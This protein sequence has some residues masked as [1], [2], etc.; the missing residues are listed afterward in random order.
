MLLRS[1]YR[2]CCRDLTHRFNLP[3][4]LIRTC[5]FTHLPLPLL[6]GVAPMHGLALGVRHAG[7]TA[8]NATSPGQQKAPLFY[9]ADGESAPKCDPDLVDV[10]RSSSPSHTYIHG[11]LDSF[12]GVVA[13]LHGLFLLLFTHDWC[14]QVV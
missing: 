9:W 8:R 4:S 13:H 5:N 11:G 3:R 10:R 2:R 7:I 6:P 12:L 1:F 14:S